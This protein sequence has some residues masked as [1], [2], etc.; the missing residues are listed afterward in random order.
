MGARCQD[1]RCALPIVLLKRV[2]RPFWPRTKA[3]YTQLL[4]KRT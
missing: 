4:D 3:L 2:V 1:A